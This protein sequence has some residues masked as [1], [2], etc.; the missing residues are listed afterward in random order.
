MLLPNSQIYCHNGK[1]LQ[2]PFGLSL[3][4]KSQASLHSEQKKMVRSETSHPAS[5]L[6]QSSAALTEHQIL[7]HLVSCTSHHCLPKQNFP[8]MEVQGG[9]L[10]SS[11]FFFRK[12]SY[13]GKPFFMLRLM[14][15]HKLDVT[16]VSTRKLFSKATKN[17]V[18]M[19]SDYFFRST[20]TQ[21]HYAYSTIKNMI[22]YSVTLL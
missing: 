11:F 1:H 18:G 17:I 9:I 4:R 20:E 2:E 6:V 10:L 22:V 14:T 21:Q 13:N 16:K 3:T 8:L 5:A 15:K 12:N 19:A 7:P